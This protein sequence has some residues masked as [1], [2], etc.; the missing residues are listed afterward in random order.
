LIDVAFPG[1]DIF[2][3]SGLPLVVFTCIVSSGADAGPPA[4]AYVFPIGDEPGGMIIVT[5]SI[6]MIHVIKLVLLK[7]LFVVLMLSPPHKSASLFC[8]RP[9]WM[10]DCSLRTVPAELFVFFKTG[11]TLRCN[12]FPC[13]YTHFFGE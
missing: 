5:N 12:T 4:I 2:I 8:S 13:M 1:A 11:E 6:T 9:G 7:F 3:H 10:A